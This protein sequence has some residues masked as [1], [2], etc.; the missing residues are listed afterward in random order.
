MRLL[1]G[2]TAPVVLLFGIV[3][4]ALA[5]PGHDVAANFW[6]GFL[7]PLSGL[8]HLLPVVAVGLWASYRN[9]RL[10]GATV[11][12]FVVATILGAAA[13]PGS[14]PLSPSH[15]G[16]I[17]ALVLVGVLIMTARVH[18]GLGIAVVG[19]FAFAQGWTH[20]VELRWDLQNPAYVLGFVV[21]TTGLLS[22]GALLGLARRT[23]VPNL[24]GAG[25]AG[26][27]IL[28]IVG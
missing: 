17:G 15:P 26:C 20:G 21:A 3:S 22:L 19:A 4:D 2:I 14:Y 27:G 12:I 7:H 1:I 9:S 8:D 5:H 25:I 23:P 11:A 28:L 24:A 16:L 6:L 18:P 10:G 13:L